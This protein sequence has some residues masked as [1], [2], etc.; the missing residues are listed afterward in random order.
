MLYKWKLTQSVLIA[1]FVFCSTAIM[2][3]Q[4]AKPVLISDYVQP[5]Y[6]QVTYKIET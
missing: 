6:D 3:Q 2:A 4:S 1:A 5:E